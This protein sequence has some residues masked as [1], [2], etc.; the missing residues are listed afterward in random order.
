MYTRFLTEQIAATQ[1][2]AQAAGAVAPAVQQQEAAAQPAGN[3]KRKG[4]GKAASGRGSKRQKGASAKAAAVNASG[5]EGSSGDDSGKTP[6][7]VTE[8]ASDLCL[9]NRNALKMTVSILQE[10][11]CVNICV[12][13]C[14]EL[15]KLLTV[16]RGYR[17]FACKDGLSW[18][19]GL[20]IAR[21]L[22]KI[23]LGRSCCVQGWWLYRSPKLESM[24]R[25][26]AMVQVC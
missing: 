25:C 26:T 10:F 17:C 2:K 1:T 18:L 6:T 16:Y 24:L 13:D 23:L 22:L 4:A 9:M 14:L 8:Q 7:Q 15:Q 19:M 11:S 5:G 3:G 21:C 12:M 20:V